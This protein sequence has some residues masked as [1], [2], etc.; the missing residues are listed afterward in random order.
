MAPINCPACGSSNVKHHRT[1]T[2]KS[3]RQTK[4]YLC[5][6]C[7]HY[8]TANSEGRDE[9]K[10]NDIDWSSESSTRAFVQGT[11]RQDAE[12][13]P[14]T[15]QDIIKKFG[16]DETIWNVE[17]FVVNEWEQGQSTKEGQPC[18]ISLYQIKLTLVRHR[19][20]E[21]EIPPIRPISFKVSPSKTRPA[22]KSQRKKAIY[23]SDA[24]IGFHRDL[25][26]GSLQPYHNRL[27]W[28]AML[29][30]LAAN[31]VDL[32]VLGGDIMDM[33]DMSDKFAQTPETHFTSQPALV[34]TGWLIGAILQALPKTAKMVYLEGNHENRLPRYL[35]N[36]FTAA[37]NVSSV[38]FAGEPLLSVPELI[39]G[40]GIDPSRIEWVG[41]YPN[42]AYWVNDSTRLIHGHVSKK[43]A[44]ATAEAYLEEVNASTIF[45][46]IHRTELASVSHHARAGQKAKTKVFTAQSFGMFGMPSQVPPFKPNHNWQQG[47]GILHYDDAECTT[48]PISLMDT[49]FAVNDE[50]YTG[51]DYTDQI[52]ED[53]EWS[54]L[55]LK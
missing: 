7:N 23:L 21:T 35:L 36:H 2:L 27:H 34:E 54:A 41:D 44:G 22:K 6:D 47:F 10:C 46:H 24:H 5:R 45:G 42:G 9:R 1:R 16:I 14:P 50:V 38:R 52:V 48:Q 11:I 8:Y 28:S 37:Y 43:R 4:Q 32:F 13:K 19:A 40:R 12:R 20:I 30:Y 33:G 26:T 53:T 17:R 3:N 49:G 31:P 39:V 15:L 29:A 25:R 51:E 18:I 55:S